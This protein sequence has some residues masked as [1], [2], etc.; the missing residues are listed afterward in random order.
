[1]ALSQ[2]LDALS[3]WPV[4]WIVVSLLASQPLAIVLTAV[5]LKL[6]GVNKDDRAKWALKHATKSWAL[7]L[8]RAV[9][10][11]DGAPAEGSSDRK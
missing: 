11:R 9:R 3:S 2:A 7:D 4:L 10:G 6:A 5:A 8:V 1:M